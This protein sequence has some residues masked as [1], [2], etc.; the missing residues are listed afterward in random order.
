MNVRDFTKNL[1]LAQ[2]EARLTWWNR[3]N[4]TPERGEIYDFIYDGG[5]KE[6]A[7]RYIDLLLEI[8]AD[9]TFLIDIECNQINDWRNLVTHQVPTNSILKINNMIANN[10]L[11]PAN[12]TYAIQYITGA[13]GAVVNLDYFS[14]NINSLPVKPNSMLKYT[15]QEY[16]NYIRL[17]L[18][19][20]INTTYSNF[21][22]STITGYN[23][24]QIWNSI[25][26]INAV[27]HINIPVAGD[28]SVMCTKYTNDSWIFT[29]LEVPFAGYPGYDGIHPVSGHREFGLKQNPNGTYTFY[30]RGVDRI[31]GMLDDIVGSSGVMGDPFQ[32][33]DALWN[34][35]LD[36]VKNHVNGNTG[37]AGTKNTVINRPK[38]E[39]V[40]DVLLGSKPKSTLGCK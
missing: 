23:E 9:P 20:F 37:Q 6:I 36:G 35:L 27:L 28:G 4:N 13:K 12:G 26:P 34:S 11:T 39:D 18:N 16:L 30:T 14:I 38:W 32:N 31:S 22:P 15:P 17:N 33:P 8:E 1:R 5:D 3:N 24:A 10:K 19:S 21:S 25:N 2:N 40:K 29:T 7:Y